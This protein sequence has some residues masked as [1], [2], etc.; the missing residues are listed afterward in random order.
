MKTPPKASADEVARTLSDIERASSCSMC[1]LH[2]VREWQLRDQIQEYEHRIVA[3][4]IERENRN[5]RVTQLYMA[6]LALVL[7]VAYLV[8]K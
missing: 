3:L 7:F 8:V 6:V 1:D 4:G 5:R 2:E